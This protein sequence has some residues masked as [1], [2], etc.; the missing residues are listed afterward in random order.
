MT[1]SSFT[2]RLDFRQALIFESIDVNLRSYG[3]SFYELCPRFV[4]F[5]IV[6]TGRIDVACGLVSASAVS[7][8][9][10]VNSSHLKGKGS[11]QTASVYPFTRALT[12]Y[13]QSNAP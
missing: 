12:R 11:G 7:S 9:M 4:L 13:F 3:L 5:P 8:V 10:A 6:G 2:L 1:A